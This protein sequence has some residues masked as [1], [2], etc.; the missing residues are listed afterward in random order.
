M[1]LF[2]ICCLVCGIFCFLK[3]MPRDM[4]KDGYQKSASN[5]L[6]RMFWI[7]VTTKRVAVYSN[8]K[9]P[10]KFTLQFERK[11]SE[12]LSTDNVKLISQGSESQLPGS[13]SKDDS[14]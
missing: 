11:L 12:S 9:I 8:L 1:L 2:C 14:F 13:S 6:R 3:D 5:T 10:V 7:I 4:P